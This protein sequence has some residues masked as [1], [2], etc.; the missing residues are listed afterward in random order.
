MYKTGSSYVVVGSVC[1]TVGV[2]GFTLGGGYSMLSRYLGL[3]IDNLVSVTM[4]TANGSSVVVANSTVH[5]DL[6]WAL[7]GGGGGNFGAVTRFSFQLHPAQPNYVFGAIKFQGDGTRLF[8]ELLKTA[9]QLPKELHFEIL[10]FPSQETILEPLYIGDF[11][12]ALD[13]APKTFH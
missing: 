2:S 5:S 8:L 13:R 10:I 6:F 11:G 4:V 1:L 9:P 7:R 3:A 12:D